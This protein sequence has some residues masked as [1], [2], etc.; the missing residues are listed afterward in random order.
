M[1]PENFKEHLNDDNPKVLHSVELRSTTL[2]LHY[3]IHFEF[4][5]H[6]EVVYALALKMI[7]NSAQVTYLIIYLLDQQ[8]ILSTIYKYSMTYH[9]GS[10]VDGPPQ[11]SV[12]PSFF[13][14]LLQMSIPYDRVFSEKIYF[15]STGIKLSRS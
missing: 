2:S 14:I 5:H 11:A 6:S 4:R 12:A 8:S 7:Y 9:A 3:L 10:Q 15:S 1:N 13:N